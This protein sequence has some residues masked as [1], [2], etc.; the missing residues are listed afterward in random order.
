MFLVARGD[1]GVDV[2]VDGEMSRGGEGA[3][4][5]RRAAAFIS[6]KLIPPFVHLALSDKTG[7]WAG[8][9][10]AALSFLFSPLSSILHL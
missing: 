1:H 4:D 2:W 8:C 5:G 10:S 3:G 9:G 6:W 7:K